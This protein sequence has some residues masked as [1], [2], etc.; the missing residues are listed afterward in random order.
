MQ[1]TPSVAI[2]EDKV[3]AQS[4]AQTKEKEKKEEEVVQVEVKQPAPKKSGWFGF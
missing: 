4:K 1:S 3:T 2:K